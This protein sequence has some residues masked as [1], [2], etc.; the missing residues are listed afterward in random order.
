MRSMRGAVEA[1]RNPMSIAVRNAHRPGYIV[2]RRIA[3]IVSTR[4]ARMTV[5]RPNLSAS[6][7]QPTVPTALASTR[8]VA[9]GP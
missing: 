3:G 2:Y 1:A 9:S 4:V 6:A 7:P 5:R 8:V